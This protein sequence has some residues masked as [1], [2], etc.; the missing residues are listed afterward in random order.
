MSKP[1]QNPTPKKAATKATKAIKPAAAPPSSTAASATVQPSPLS[2]E[3][4]KLAVHEAVSSGK[5]AELDALKPTHIIVRAKDDRGFRRAGR[6]WPAVETT[7]SVDEFSAEQ[8]AALVEE[9]ELVVAFLVVG[10]DDAL[11]LEGDEQ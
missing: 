10:A 5:P 6:F 3:E 4:M 9:S 11:P 1:A 8:I 2:F 7:V